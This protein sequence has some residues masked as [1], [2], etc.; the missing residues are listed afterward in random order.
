[1]TKFEILPTLKEISEVAMAERRVLEAEM[2][3]EKFDE[4]NIQADAAIRDEFDALTARAAK[5]A[6]VNFELDRL[7]EY[8]ELFS[9][10][11]GL[12]KEWADD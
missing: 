3:T 12:N 1:M 9:I 2:W 11:M 5:W 7:I 10:R 8:V 4:E 6:H